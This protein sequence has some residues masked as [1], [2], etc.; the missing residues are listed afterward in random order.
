MNLFIIVPGVI[1]ALLSSAVIAY[2]SMATMVGPWIG[3]TLVLVSSLMLKFRRFK[4]SDEV[5]H[6]ELALIQSIGSVGGIVG[7]A[8]GFSLPTLFFLDPTYFRS[9]L[10]SPLYFCAMITSICLSAGGLGIVIARMLSEKLIIKESLPF[11]VSHLI[12]RTIT[13]HSDGREARAMLYGFFSTGIFCFLRDG[14]WFLKGILPRTLYVLRPFIGKELAIS[15]WPT[16][17]AIGFTTG[18]FITIPL[19]AGMLAKYF[20]LYPI[21][22]HSLY[23]PFALFPVLSTTE[24]TVAFCS[25][26]VL[27][28]V[29]FG[30]TRYPKM[31]WATMQSMIP[32]Y[33]QKLKAKGFSF[34]SKNHPGMLVVRPELFVG[35]GTL[36]R[37]HAELIIVILASMM[38]LSFLEFTL[39]TQFFLLSLVFIATY[40]I[41]YLGAKIGMVPFGRFATFVMVPTMLLFPLSYLQITMVCVFVNVCVGVASDLLFDYKVGQLCNISF[42][43]VYR[44]QWLG[45]IVTSI[46]IGFILW[47]LFTHFELGSAELCAQRGRARALLIQ[48]T[49]FNY[50]VLS[51][52]ILFGL[53]IK[54]IKINPALMLG[55]ILMPNSIS[56]GLILGGLSSRL[57][58]Q[59]DTHLPFWSGVFAS[60]SLWIIVGILMKFCGI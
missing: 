32:T 56:I 41:A 10:A 39:A 24:F 57:F 29:A 49:G 55:G 58:K 50:W 37:T 40:Q 44:Y 3:P 21:N 27:A 19:L 47:L 1:F 14:F 36:V 12:H 6:E 54:K 60:E 35:I 46:G 15:L 43:K 16:L 17:W 22:H 13:S 33:I 18:S 45:L 7:M 26:L 42:E 5:V 23:I 2:V 53:A 34:T 28:E 8:I 59:P 52:G 38:C 4:P 31:I 9:L 25:G 48:S 11:P 51:L 30:I 20:V